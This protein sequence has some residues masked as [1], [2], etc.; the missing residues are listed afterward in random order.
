MK[1]PLDPGTLDMS[2]VW[3]ECFA[4]VVAV[5]QHKV[6][7]AV[8]GHEAVTVVASKLHNNVAVGDIVGEPQVDGVAGVTQD[9]LPG[10]G[11]VSREI[12]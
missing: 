3:G 6:A 9:T 4:E 7:A 12:G 10:F 11:V 1:D 8:G 2:S 5:N